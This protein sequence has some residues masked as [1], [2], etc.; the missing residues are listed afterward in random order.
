M[1]GE[2]ELK[3]GDIPAARS[4][5]QLPPSERRTQAVTTEGLARAG[6]GHAVGRES[7]A[8][9]ETPYRRLGPRAEDAVD[10]PGVQAASPQPDLERG[11]IRVAPGKCPGR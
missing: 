3:R 1:P 6:P 4:E 8:L 7:L 5:G 2:R 9:L 10:G 11:D